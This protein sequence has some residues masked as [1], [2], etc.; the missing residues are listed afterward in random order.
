[1]EEDDHAARAATMCPNPG[2]AHRRHLGGCRWFI[3]RCAVGCYEPLAVTRSAGGGAGRVAGSVPVNTAPPSW[4]VVAVTWA[5]VRRDRTLEA[6]S[7]V[8]AEMSASDAGPVCVRASSSWARLTAVSCRLAWAGVRI[9]CE[10]SIASTCTG[11]WRVQAR[12]VLEEKILWSSRTA[13]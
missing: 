3:A 1:M 12:W 10:L 11:N 5:A 6:L 7:P 8:W 13:N 4:L 9:T 2:V